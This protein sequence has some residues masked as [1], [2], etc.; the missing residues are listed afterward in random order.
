MRERSAN[1]KSFNLSCSQHRRGH[2]IH[3]GPLA[4]VKLTTVEVTQ[5]PQGTGYV[6]GS[7]ITCYTSPESSYAPHRIRICIFIHEA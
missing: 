4:A 5:L 6:G 1:H 3:N 7:G 2:R